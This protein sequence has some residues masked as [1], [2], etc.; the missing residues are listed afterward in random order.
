MG[1]DAGA[2]KR[3]K[4]D[5]LPVKEIDE[6]TDAE[7]DGDRADFVVR[8][9]DPPGI[10]VLLETAAIDIVEIVADFSMPILKKYISKIENQTSGREIARVTMSFLPR[11]TAMEVHTSN[12]HNKHFF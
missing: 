1:L 9:S 2:G 5:D 8:E 3:A 6:L 12:N 7:D 4:K 11:V 10:R